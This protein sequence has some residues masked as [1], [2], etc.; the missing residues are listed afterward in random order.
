[1]TL[2]LPDQKEVD[3]QAALKALKNYELSENYKALFT[4]VQAQKDKVKATLVT[5][6][7]TPSED[8]EIFTEVKKYNHKNKAAWCIEALSDILAVIDENDEGGKIIRKDIQDEIERAE[9]NIGLFMVKHFP[10]SGSMVEYRYTDV[11]FTD[12]DRLVYKFYQWEGMLE[13]IAKL[14]NTYSKEA[15]E[16]VDGGVTEEPQHDA[17]LFDTREDE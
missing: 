5:A 17:V 1:M 11:D 13:R 12:S 15:T 14:I 6:Y 4:E 16:D 3:R 9:E 10:G 7:L 8:G 2:E